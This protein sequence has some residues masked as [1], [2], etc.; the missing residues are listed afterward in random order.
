MIFNERE[1]YSYSSS[2]D[3]EYAANSVSEADAVYTGST[4]L[5]RPI[6]AATRG[7][8]ILGVNE[9]GQTVTEGRAG[10]GTFVETVKAAIFKG[11][12]S[13]ELS[14]VPAG[15]EPGTG[16]E[17]Y[18]VQK[19][20][21]LRELARANEIKIASVHTPSQIGN[22][23]GFAGPERGFV[24][25][26]REAF[27]NEVKKA[28]NFA[29][30]V[31][32]GG[33][34]VVHTGEYQRPMS[35]QA[36][37]RDE[38]GRY[39]FKHYEEEP[40]RAIMRIV[41]DRTGQVIQQV[42]KNQEVYRPIWLRA[43][44]D[45]EYL[46]ENGQ[47]VQVKKGDYIDYEKRKLT[48]ESRVPVYD[49]ES[50]R[51]RVRKM[52]WDDF[53]EEAKERNMERPQEEWITPEEAL[54][55][56]NIETNAGQARGWALYH[57]VQMRQFQEKL[58]KFKKSLDFYKQLEAATPEEDKWQLKR[59]FEQDYGILPKDMKLP[60]EFLEKEIRDY[61]SHIEHT[62][63]ASIGYEQQAKEQELFKS[64]AKPIERYA[65][66]KSATSYA[67]VGIYAMDQTNARRLPKPVF[68]APE[69]VFPEMGYGSHPEEMIELVQMGRQ[70]MAE[71]LMRERGFNEDQAKKAAAQH[72]KATLDTEHIGMW[73]R[74]YQRHEGENEAQFTQRFNE[75]YMEQIKKMDKAGIIGH[76]HIAD[77]FGYGHANLPAGHG[78]MPVVDAIAYLKKRGYTG[79]YLSEGY[80]DVTR[81]LTEAWKTFG[82]PIYSAAGPVR[83][84]A[85]VR[86]SDVQNSYFGR[87]QMPYYVFGSYSPS[88]DWTLWSQVPLE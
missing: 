37:A 24:D 8:P 40:E 13:V 75:W 80:G 48:G 14:A 45:Y 50:G 44:D 74:Y 54:L 85:P 9:I 84:G 60:S 39:I 5:N 29:A 77:G 67:E 79:A 81:M 52:V 66:E 17:S 73:K 2:M 55:H 68:V 16:V 64:H 25:E 86:W 63:Q 87:G 62:H 32:Q 70:R 71:R 57:G 38:Y 6:R 4:N 51:F 72:I 76:I 56:A 22:L 35:E 15:S 49:T 11:A 21:D 19:R 83:P 36:W 30:D 31:T 12:A 27:V 69:Q 59:Q 78:D 41:D 20:E 65:K 7:E 33:A 88:N 18:G 42:R 3:R 61:R 23:S 47:K 1:P 34:V 28:V 10:G 46:N 82:S 53:V 58:E 43:D 26:Q